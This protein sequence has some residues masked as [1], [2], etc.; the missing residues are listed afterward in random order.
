MPFASIKVPEAANLPVRDEKGCRPGCAMC[1]QSMP[2]RTAAPIAFRRTTRRP[3]S[4]RKIPMVSATPATMTAATA[5]RSIT[6]AGWW[7][8]KVPGQAPR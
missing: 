4:G 8:G 6:A 3:L 5:Q 2:V 7:P 1:Q